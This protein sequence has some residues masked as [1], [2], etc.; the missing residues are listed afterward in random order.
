MKISDLPELTE[1]AGGGYL[2]IVANGTTYKI[3][4]S[5]LAGS[6]GPATAPP[7]ALNDEFDGETL[8]S[9]WTW[10][11]KGS[12]TATVSNGFLALS[13]P[14]GGSGG[15]STLYKS[16]PNSEIWSCTAKITITGTANH[17]TGQFL[18][19]RNADGRL[20][21]FGS[22]RSPSA[23]V[24]V[25][26]RFSNFSSYNSAPYVGS[27]GN[28]MGELGSTYFVRASVN[29]SQ[30]KFYAAIEE[31]QLGEP[32]ALYHSEA[33]SNW[34]GSVNSLGFSLDSVNGGT[35]G[36][37]VDFVKFTEG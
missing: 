30:V 1:L 34:L 31:A 12:S 26:Y 17:N 9:D 28:G 35:A 4:A 13:K 6:G 3:A 19:L 10:E 15:F 7:N 36:L 23:Q 24:S 37:K 8:S 14:P 11:N 2:V 5:L 25:V 32:T 29:E 27:L 18:A 20:L 33:K 21:L 22:V 16:P